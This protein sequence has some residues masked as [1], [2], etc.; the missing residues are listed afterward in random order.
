[1]YQPTDLKKGT[2]ISIDGKPFKV[3]D[4]SQKVMGRG[5]HADAQG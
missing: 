1:M 5:G 3:I 2:V 4:Y